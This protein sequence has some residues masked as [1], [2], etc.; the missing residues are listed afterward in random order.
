MV[1]KVFKRRCDPNCSFRTVYATP[2]WRIGM[3]WV[4]RSETRCT[5]APARWCTQ[6]QF[7]DATHGMGAPWRYVRTFDAGT[8]TAQEQHGTCSLLIKIIKTLHVYDGSNDPKFLIKSSPSS[9]LLM[10]RGRRYGHFRKGGAVHGRD[11]QHEPS[12]RP[13]ETR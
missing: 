3:G 6:H 12:E 9:E 4:V 1:T 13:F 11:R 8:G 10:D 7:C 5:K 2:D